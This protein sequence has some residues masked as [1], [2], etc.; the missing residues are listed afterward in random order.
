M[1]RCKLWHY[2]AAGEFT[3]FP[4]EEAALHPD[5]GTGARLIWTVDAATWDKVKIP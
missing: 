2:E 1:K 3:F 5:R 4:A